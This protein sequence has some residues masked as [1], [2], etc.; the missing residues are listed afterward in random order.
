MVKNNM[1]N[2]S[3]HI[4]SGSIIPNVG[5]P[6]ETVVIG[7][8]GTPTAIIIFRGKI[9]VYDTDGQT[10]IDGGYITAK[11]LESVIITA[12]K[13]NINAQKFINNIE[14][15]ATDNNT[16]SWNNG[17]IIFL[18]GTIITVYA[19][20]TGN[21]TANTYIYY[22]GTSSLKK[23]TYISS[24]M[25]GNNIP[26][27]IIEPVLVG[28]C[29]VTPFL[30]NGTTIDGNNITT[31]KIQ[32]FNGKT[33]FDLNNNY[34]KITDSSNDVR[35][36]VG[37]MSDGSYGIKVSLPGYDAETETDI[38]NFALWS[39]SSDSVDNVLIKEKTRG[40]VSVDGGGY[41]DK[42]EM[43]HGLEYVPFCLVFFEESSGKFTKCSGSTIDGGGGYYTINATNLT[44]INNTGLTKS[45]KYYIFYDQM[46]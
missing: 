19:G 6:I 31:G 35:V 34:I 4:K 22:D 26:L 17:D 3:N 44:F 32:S 10:L 11:A 37:K 30:S 24:A 41:A 5:G 45:F 12:D 29:I 14:F 16:C 15:T 8:P 2:L 39:T 40:S 28:K 33:Y 9:F 23:T 25:Y 42:E 1:S 38:N 43:V 21:I 18:D 20:N 46:A 7:L 13:L 36:I 27:A